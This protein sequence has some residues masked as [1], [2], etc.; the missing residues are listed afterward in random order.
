MDKHVLHRMING[1][2]VRV[3]GGIFD[4]HRSGRDE[5]G[6][7]VEIIHHQLGQR[8]QTVEGTVDG[9]RCEGDHSRAR[10]RGGRN[11]Q[12]IRLVRGK[13]RVRFGV[14]RDGDFH[15]VHGLLAMLGIVHSMVEDQFVVAV[16]RLR[17][18]LHIAIFRHVLER[19]N[20]C[21][22]LAS[23]EGLGLRK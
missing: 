14:V 21:L 4:L 9:L 17:Q 16:I 22:A 7:G 15:L 10:L 11:V 6:I 20:V 13:L 12:R 8:L 3:S 19:E 23:Y 18:S 2:S 1:T 5:V